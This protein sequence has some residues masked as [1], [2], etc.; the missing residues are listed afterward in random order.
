MQVPHRKTLDPNGNR[1]QDLLDVRHG[2]HHRTIPVVLCEYVCTLRDIM[3]DFIRGRLFLVEPIKKCL[4]ETSKITWELCVFR[5]LCATKQ[6]WK[7][8]SLYKSYM[9]L[10]HWTFIQFEMK[11]SMSNGIGTENWVALTFLHK[12]KICPRNWTILSWHRLKL[13]SKLYKV[14]HE[15]DAQIRS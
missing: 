8:K 11:N 3:K 1:T 4:Q 7:K 15:M 6:K 13:P 14:F 12:I 9:I 5:F 10:S 2:G